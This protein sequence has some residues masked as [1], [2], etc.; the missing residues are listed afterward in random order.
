MKPGAVLDGRYELVRML[1]KGAMGAVWQGN[2]LRLGRPVAVKTVRDHPDRRLLDRMGREATTAGQ[3]S[4]PHIVTVHDYGRTEY[5]DLPVTYIVMEFVDG[6]PLTSVMA[7]GRPELSVALGWARQIALALG[8]AHAPEVDVVHRDLK[9][10]N[11]LITGDGLVKVVDFGIARFMDDGPTADARLTHPGTMFGTPAYMAPEQCLSRPVDGRTDLYALGCLLYEMV[12]G[13]PPFAEGSP[14]TVAL[15][16]IRHVPAAPRSR[17]SAVSPEL[18]LLI[19]ELL[20]KNPELRPPD[21]AAVYRRLGVVAAARA[22]E[23]AD[24]LR[25]AQSRR[26]SAPVPRP[27]VKDI[28][29]AELLHR[30]GGPHALS[31]EDDPAAAVLLWDGAVAEL[32]ETVGATHPQTLTARRALAWHT[33]ACGD[34]ARAVAMWRALLPDARNVL[35]RFHDSAY[36][37]QRMLAWNT[38]VVGR[39]AQAVRLLTEL[40]PD[41][42]RL[43]GRRHPDILEARRFLAWNTGAMGRHA[44][45]VRLLRRLLPALRE[46]L[47]ADHEHTLEARRMLA[48]NTGQSGDLVKAVALLRDLVPDTTRALGGGHPQTAEAVRLLDRYTQ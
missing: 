22:D 19:R 17:N 4:H 25:Q 36:T 43:L 31:I 24:A 11:V 42:T 45:A 7:E 20:A 18:D 15:S 2:D 27:P 21:A 48:W 6:R 40:L 10:D 14:G 28:P 29:Y 9:P 47:G 1:G 38:G 35:G 41:A 13:A 30:F 8:A 44:R 39:P 12:T 37:A 23:T 3:L 5:D 26:P 33:G 16:Q 34:H 46:T 32:T